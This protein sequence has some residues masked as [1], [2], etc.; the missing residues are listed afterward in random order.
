MA[1]PNEDQEAETRSTPTN[2]NLPQL[3]AVFA[4]VDLEQRRV[5]IEFD[6]CGKSKPCLARLLTRFASSHVIT[7]DM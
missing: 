2:R 3:A 4:I 7:W 1:A 5:E 6:N